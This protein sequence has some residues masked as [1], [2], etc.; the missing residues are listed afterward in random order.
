[1]HPITLH[2]YRH[3]ER[4]RSLNKVDTGSC[5]RD[6]LL[7]TL[8]LSRAAGILTIAT[9]TTTGTPLAFT[10]TAGVTLFHPSTDPDVIRELGYYYGLH[11]PLADDPH[12][13]QAHCWLERDLTTGHI[14]LDR[15]IHRIPLTSPSDDPDVSDPARLARLAL[16][17]SILYTLGMQEETD[18][19]LAQRLFPTLAQQALTA[20]TSDRYEL[21]RRAIT[22]AANVNSITIRSC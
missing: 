20:P 22:L 3:D 7:D 11:H 14:I 4:E 6:E 15:D 8:L 2:E 18:S 9:D 10:D 5:P 13:D 12:D 19:P 16:A 21:T 17:Q 1:M